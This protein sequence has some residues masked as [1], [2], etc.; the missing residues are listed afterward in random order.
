MSLNRAHEKLHTAVRVMASSTSSLQ[1]RLAAAW[2]EISGVEP[3]AD[4][5][6]DLRDDFERAVESMGE[7]PEMFEGEG[8]VSA[9]VRVMSDAEAKRAI[10]Q[11]VSI[12]DDTTR[13]WGRTLH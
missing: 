8:S 9:T 2:K 6:P 3:E 4:W 13:Y 5:P 7:Q 1:E 11:I 12:Y 10:S